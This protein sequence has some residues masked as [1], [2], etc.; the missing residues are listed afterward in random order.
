SP[1]AV[2]VKAKTGE[3]V[4]PVGRE[5]AMTAEAVVLLCREAAA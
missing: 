2:N 5:E 3:R 1:D 4:G